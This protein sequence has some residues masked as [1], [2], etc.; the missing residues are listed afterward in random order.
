V[1]NLTV[2]IDVFKFSPFIIRLWA[3]KEREREQDLRSPFI[4]EKTS[5]P[6][7]IPQKSSSVQAEFICF[8]KS[9]FYAS[10]STEYIHYKNFHHTAGKDNSFLNFYL[11][12]R[13][14]GLIKMLN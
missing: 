5:F 1:E 11:T 14:T 12:A 9:W 4:A 3:K 7:G 2:G 10:L 13:F 8:P 6:I